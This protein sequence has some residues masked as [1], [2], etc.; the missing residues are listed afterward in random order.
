M[1][2]LTKYTNSLELEEL[3]GD[4][5]KTIVPK[6]S[7]RFKNLKGLRFGYSVVLELIDRGGKGKP[8]KWE[9]IC[10]CGAKH[11]KTSAFIRATINKNSKCVGSCNA[12]CGADLNNR[13]QIQENIVALEILA[14]GL[15]EKWG[16]E[17]GIG[18]LRQAQ[19]N[20]CKYYLTGDQCANGH[21]DAKATNRRQCLQC[22]SDE[23]RSKAAKDRGKKWRENNQETYLEYGKLII[24]KM[25]KR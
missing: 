17:I 6:G 10:D 9:C 15:E 16:I 25:Q 8:S 24:K 2:N 18:T 22:R 19:E 20:D 4:Y 14:K 11:T 5:W 7:T 1:I 3:V 12:K 23:R 21:I 13:K